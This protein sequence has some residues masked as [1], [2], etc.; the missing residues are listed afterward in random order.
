MIVGQIR[1]GFGKGIA[2]TALQLLLNE[3]QSRP[4]S[5]H[6]ASSNRASLRVLQKSGFVVERAYLSPATDRYLE[7]EETLLVLR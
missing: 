7:C 6:V 5:A 1:P 2:S 3:I 4:L